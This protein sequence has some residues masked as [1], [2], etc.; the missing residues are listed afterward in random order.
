MKPGN[1][2]IQGAKS[3]GKRKMR[4]PNVITALRISE[5]VFLWAPFAGGGPACVERKNQKW[6]NDCL[7]LNA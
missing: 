5:R 1:L 6:K 4:F 7:L 3:G 2:L